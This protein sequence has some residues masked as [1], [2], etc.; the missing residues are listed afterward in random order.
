MIKALVTV[1]EGRFPSGLSGMQDYPLTDVCNLW[2]SSLKGVR[3]SLITCFESPPG[4][5][6]C[7]VGMWASGG[8]NGVEQ[9]GLLHVR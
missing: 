2:D 8:K 6:L 7:A 5:G 9:G 1:G 4:T 3:Q